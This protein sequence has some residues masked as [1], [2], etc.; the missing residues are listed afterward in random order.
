MTKE[1]ITKTEAFLKATIALSSY[2]QANPKVW[3]TSDADC[4]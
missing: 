4:D 1:M 3:Q 2:F